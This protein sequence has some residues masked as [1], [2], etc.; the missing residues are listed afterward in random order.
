MPNDLNIGDVASRT[1]RSIH[2]IRWYEAQGLMPGVTR[3]GAK[4]RVYTEHHIGWLDLMER[5]RCTGMSIAQMRTYTELV[6][7]GSATL[8]ERRELLRDH[9]ARVRET[10]ARWH[11][12]LALI[13]A[14][15]EFYDEWVASGER[16]AVS[17]HRRMR[18]KSERAPSRLATPLKSHLARRIRGRR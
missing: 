3:D 17:P 8:N 9:R 16:P 14:K 13:E 6:K 5:L 10:I 2:T 18:A 4:R 12:A 15:I 11:D 7:D 1:G